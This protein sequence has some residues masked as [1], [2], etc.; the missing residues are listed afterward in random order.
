MSASEP[1]GCFSA[2]K[3]HQMPEAV[4]PAAQKLSNPVSAGSQPLR[5]RPSHCAEGSLIIA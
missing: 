5:A 4:A 2:V 1:A 3:E